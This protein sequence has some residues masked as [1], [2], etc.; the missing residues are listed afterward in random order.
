MGMRDLEKETAMP[1]KKTLVVVAASIALTSLR[2][3]FASKDI[4]DNRDRP[5]G[6]VVPC[7][8][9][10]VNPA[11]HPEIFGNP[12]VAAAYGFVRS[13]DGAWRVGPTCRR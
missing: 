8:L 11:Y 4:I 5:G 1:G 10:G 3:A 6:A 2:P 7:S 12:A 9:V 13:A